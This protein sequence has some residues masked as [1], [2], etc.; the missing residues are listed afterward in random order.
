[1]RWLRIERVLGLSCPLCGAPLDRPGLCIRC[2]NTLR[3]GRRHNLVF[4]GRYR[5][6]RRVVR[7][8]KFRGGRAL[9]PPLARALAEGVREAGWDVEA[10]T[11]VPTT[12]WRIWR[13]GYNPAELLGRAI[14]R[15]LG[16]PYRRVLGRRYF[17]SQT[18]RPA[19]LRASLPAGIFYLRREL[20]ERRWLLV[21]DVWTTGATFRAVE[22][23]LRAGG[24]E[25]V[26]GAVI[27]ARRSS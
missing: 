9:V 13:R 19:D 23:A 20:P 5:E 7:A 14:A 18:R 11:A 24:A 12:W 3:A 21:D 16:V 6:Y 1:V 8:L 2:T 4:L 10:V 15:E 22:R 26:W 17:R 25:A 27:A